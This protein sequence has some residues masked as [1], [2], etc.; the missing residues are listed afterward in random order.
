M[1]K[2]VITIDEG[3]VCGIQ[4]I[5]N[6]YIVNFGMTFFDQIFFGCAIQIQ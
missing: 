3:G 2:F 1:G 6:N 4:N 5:W